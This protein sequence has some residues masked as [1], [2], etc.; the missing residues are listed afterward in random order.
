MKEITVEEYDKAMGKKIKEIRDFPIEEQLVMLLE[1]CAKYKI[2][3]RSKTKK[4]TKEK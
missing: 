1:E 4:N 2:Y 3:E